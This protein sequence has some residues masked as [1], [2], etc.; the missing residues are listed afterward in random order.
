MTDYLLMVKPSGRDELFKSF[1]ESLPSEAELLFESS[2][3]Y[4]RNQ[5]FFGPRDKDSVHFAS[6]ILMS[7]KKELR[8]WNRE[9]TG[10]DII[11]IPQLE[12]KVYANASTDIV[13]CTPFFS[14]TNSCLANMT[15][16]DALII[17]N[18]YVVGEI[19]EDESDNVTVSDYLLIREALLKYKE[20][21]SNPQVQFAQ[22]YR[23]YKML[24]DMIRKNR[25]K[26]SQ[27]KYAGTLITCLESRN[28]KLILQ[29]RAIHKLDVSTLER[30]PEFDLVQFDPRESRA[31]ASMKKIPSLSNETSTRFYGPEEVLLDYGIT[32]FFSNEEFPFTTFAKQKEDFVKTAK[33]SKDYHH[34][35]VLYEG[36]PNEDMEFMVGVSR[37][38]EHTP[39]NNLDR[40]SINELCLG[41]IDKNKE[42]PLTGKRIVG[43][44]IYDFQNK[45]VHRKLDCS[46]VDRAGQ[47]GIFYTPDD[48]CPIKF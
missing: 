2:F 31:K 46:F 6:R 27:D 24:Y 43:V 29:E 11:A 5:N 32:Y 47:E 19:A 4:L 13:D 23:K 41:L 36:S 22:D 8:E 15:D 3:G 44:G 34:S 42:I 10:V 30:I 21:C 16:E 26:L 45:V 48:N 1:E 18:E 12:V 39:L 25:K 20:I 28:G 37:I 9:M 17:K 40:R 38:F 35:I 7:E 33:R 14:G